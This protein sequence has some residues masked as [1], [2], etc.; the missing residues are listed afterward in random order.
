MNWKGSST[1]RS[2]HILRYC[3]ISIFSKGPRKVTENIDH[4]SRCFG[5]Y[6]NLTLPE[7]E[8]TALPVSQTGRCLTRVSWFAGQDTNPESPEYKAGVLLTG[9][10]H[11]V[12]KEL[13]TQN[14]GGTFH[15]QLYPGRGQ[16]S[17]SHYIGIG[18]SVSLVVC[19]GGYVSQPCARKV[20]ICSTRCPVL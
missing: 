20:L 1:K 13:E 5:L 15:V 10:R 3:I 17:R 18:S 4:E 7:N 12:K 6:S 11:S 14:D 2:W 9:P 16:D 8:F 19:L